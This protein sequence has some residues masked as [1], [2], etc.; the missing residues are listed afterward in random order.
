[1][2]NAV[3]E[4][5]EQIAEEL[6]ILRQE[7]QHLDGW[8]REIVFYKPPEVL[9]EMVNDQ[10]IM[11]KIARLEQLH[12]AIQQKESALNNYNNRRN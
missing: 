11:S 8:F 5:A 1:M 7:F 9:R 2:A 4:P 10:N 3:F 12:V 6:D